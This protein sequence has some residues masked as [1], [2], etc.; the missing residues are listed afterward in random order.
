MGGHIGFSFDPGSLASWLLG[1]KF[2]VRGC[3]DQLEIWFKV[4]TFS[5]PYC[6]YGPLGASGVKVF[7]LETLLVDS[8]MVR[9]S[10]TLNW[11]SLKLAQ[12]C[13]GGHKVV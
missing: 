9:L 10:G 6:P 13:A 1:K 12:I 7:F 5:E 11:K 2:K 4:G 3:W 8:P